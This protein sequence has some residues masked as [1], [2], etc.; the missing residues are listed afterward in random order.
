MARTPLDDTG[1]NLL[2]R[3]ART[4]S[5]WV[6]G[7]VSDEILRQIFD[8]MK[9]APTSANCSPARFVFVTSPEGKEKLKP[10][11][12]SG[13]VEQTMA[14]AAT[15]IIAY[16]MEFYEHLPKLYPPADAKSWFTGN[17]KLIYETAFRNGSLQG[18]YLM[19]AARA[20]GFDC[21]PM[22]GFDEDTLNAAF[23]PDGRFKANFLCN[24]GHGDDDKVYPRTP[25]FDF[26]E[27][28]E[29]V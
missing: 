16:D 19:M 20:L 12:S 10:A 17:D 26:N 5:K 1:L 6:D 4:H 15:A 11:L 25:R 24:I 18:A 22:S 8:L 14:A 2:F 13:N 9:M 27:A 7:V 28:C 29:V 3:D 21:G 23:F